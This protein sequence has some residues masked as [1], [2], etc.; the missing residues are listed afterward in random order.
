MKNDDLA[1]I[2]DGLRAQPARLPPKLFYDRLGSTLFTAIC[3]LP[4]Y[5]PTRTEAILFEA[6]GA[7]IARLLPPGFQMI[8]LGAGDCR[9]AASLFDTLRPPH[10]VAVDISAEFLDRALGI[11]RR[12][13]PAIEMHALA[14]DF[15]RRW[16]LPEA[17][18]DRPQLFFYPGS[19]IGNFAP[20]EAR[21][22]LAGLHGIGTRSGAEEALLIGVDLVK[23]PTVLEAA[24]DD[25]LGVTAA[26][27]RNALL[28][29]NRLLGS[30]FALA[31]WRHRA[32]FDRERSRIEMH[33]EAVRDVT[34]GWPGG[35]RRFRRGE[36]IHTE[37]SY[38]YTRDGFEALL[39]E[40]GFA[41]VAAWTDPRQW[42][43]VCVA[44]STR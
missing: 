26:F 5:Y 28:H 17:L 38:K 20:S 40:A 10:Y 32:W 41:V 23:D 6:H 39:D 19:S 1:Q 21:E 37:N 4:E 30:D 25:A 9:K 27:N 43:M 22:F 16:S 13:F 7:E 3:E 12:E 29:L 14:R 33:L 15:T 24:Y 31:D 18:R 44:R 11:L 42:F 35:T 2:A 8:D 34:V 36:T